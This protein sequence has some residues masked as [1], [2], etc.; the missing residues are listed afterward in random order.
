MSIV[1][2][3]LLG[4]AVT[5]ALSGT[6]IEASPAPEETRRGAS[7]VGLDPPSDGVI[8]AGFAPGP[9]YS[10][11]WGVDYGGSSDGSVRAAAGGRVTF[12]GSVVG[13]LAVTLD[14]G[15]GL[16]TSYSYLDRSLVKRGQH[17]GRGMVVGL[18]SEHSPHGGLHFSVR[19]G[20][21]C[22]DPETV[23]GCRPSSPSWGHRL[24]PVRR[25]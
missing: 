20:G 25:F 22:I 13:N 6:N 24:V 10:G 16:K 18:V 2:P 23:L 14:H 15:G 7:C 1:R 5:V 11:H 12:T 19:I 8:T 9:G 17:L 3:L 4:L 21:K